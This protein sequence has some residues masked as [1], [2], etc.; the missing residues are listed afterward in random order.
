MDLVTQSPTT[1][2]RFGFMFKNQPPHAGLGDAAHATWV[3]PWRNSPSSA[4]SRPDTGRRHANE[5][6]NDR[7]NENPNPLLTSGFTFVGQFVDH[8]ITFDTTPLDQQQSDPYATTNFRTPRYDLDA[9]Y[10]RGPN[11]DPQFY[12]PNDR[13]KFLIDEAYLQQDQGLDHD[14]DE[15]QHRLRRQADVVWDVPRDAAGKAIIADPRNDQTLIILQLHVAMQM[16]HNKLVDLHAG[17]PG[18]PGGGVRVGPASGPVALPVDGDPRLPARHRG[19]GHDRLGVQG[20]PDRGADHQH[21]V[22]QADEPPGTPLHPGR[23]LGGRIPLRPQHHPA[24]LHRPG[25]HQQ[26]RR[27]R[28][29]LERAAVRGRGRATTT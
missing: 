11:V 25:R 24:P 15:A 1:E 29:R 22:L 9:I 20:S 3:W 4:A 16:F 10:G 12:D 26:R 19:Q 27:H 14:P 17:N 5:G 18:A 7:F 23:V 8:D 2:G 28:G 6:H 13:D 21:Q